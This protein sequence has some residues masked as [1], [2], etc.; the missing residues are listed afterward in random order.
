MQGLFG[1]MR[2]ALLQLMMALLIP[3]IWWVVTSRKISFLKWIGFIKPKFNQSFMKSIG[4][5]LSVT[6]GY[7]FAMQYI[8]IHCIGLSQTAGASFTG[9]GLM[10]LPQ[11]LVYAIFQTSLSEEL[12]FR[13]FLCKRLTHQLGFVAG[14]SVQALCFGLIHGIPFG[15]VT[16]SLLVGFMMTLLPAIMGYMQGWLNEKRANGSIVPSWI[17]HAV[18]NILSGIT[19]AL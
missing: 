11:I 2:T 17:L 19:A 18:M 3:V 13:G 14:N 5:V 9:K 10:V 8:V 12:F 7:I 6:I 15:L 1:I 16:G 4:I